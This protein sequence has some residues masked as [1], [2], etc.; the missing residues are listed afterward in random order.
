MPRVALQSLTGD[1]AKSLDATATAGALDAADHIGLIVYNTAKNETASDRRCPGLHVWDGNEWKP[2]KQY[3]PVQE[4]SEPLIR[5]IGFRYLDPDSDTDWPADKLADRAAGKYAIGRL[6]AANMAE[7]LTDNRPN[8]GTKTY[9]VSRFYVGFKIYNIIARIERS[10]KCSADDTPTWEFVEDKDELVETFSDGIWMTENLRALHLPDGTPLNKTFVDNGNPN[11]LP[12]NG[13]DANIELYGALYNWQAAA[14]GYIQTTDDQG[15]TSGNGKPDYVLVQGICP[16]GWHLPSDQ[17][18]TDLDNGIAR[19]PG[20]FSSILTGTTQS[21][22]NDTSTNRGGTLG[23]VMQ[24]TTQLG[25]G[26]TGSSST[27]TAGGFDAYMTGYGTH[28]SFG[29]TQYGNQ[30]FFWSSSNWGSS[31]GNAWRRSFAPAYARNGGSKGVLS[32]VRCMVDT[33]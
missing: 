22:Y 5:R 29:T 15:G 17:E 32:S 23:K 6:G 11:Y 1:L 16:D 30:A 10:Y 26:T 12:P 7:D 9:T 31:S 2:I 13:N 25:T 20:Y 4:R 28:S 8:D 3:Y 33:K 18:W 24:S 27:N 14:F 21:G 19:T